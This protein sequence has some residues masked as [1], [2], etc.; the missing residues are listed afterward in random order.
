VSDRP[1]LDRVQVMG[2]VMQ[3]LM[4][5]GARPEGDP[6]EVGA[7]VVIADGRFVLAGLPVAREAFGRLG[8]RCRPMADEGSV[9]DA[10]TVVAELGGP[11]AAMR[12]AA[13]TAFRLL[14][15]LS[16]VA[17]ELRPPEAGDPLDGYAAR[18]SPGEPVGDD[19]PS[20]HLETR[21]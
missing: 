12:G 14:A 11:L 17:S 21:V 13:P 20:F 19:G 15:R 8:A 1:A 3:A 5:D 16:A 7:G 4:S 9:V 2:V 10:G 18:L 6:A